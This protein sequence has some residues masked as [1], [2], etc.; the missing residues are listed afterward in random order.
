MS[1]LILRPFLLDHYRAIGGDNLN[2]AIVNRVTGPAFTLFDGR[3]ILGM[4][5]IRVQGIGQAWILLM[6]GAE[7]RAKTIL[8]YSRAAIEEAMAREK[9]YRL[10][11]EA[12]VEK[13]AWFKHLG[14]VQ[15]NNL[16]V[17]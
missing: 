16:Y 3:E 10:Y 13:P 8:R 2:A 6:P 11:A 17:R 12:S 14:F 5:G 15:Q 1:E 7:R 4:G 9:V